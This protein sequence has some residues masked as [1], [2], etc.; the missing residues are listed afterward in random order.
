M[1]FRLSFRARFVP[2]QFPLHSLTGWGCSH[3]FPSSKRG[4]LHFPSHRGFAPGGEVGEDL[5]ESRGG[6]LGAALPDS[7]RASLAH[8]DTWGQWPG[9]GFLGCCLN[10]SWALAPTPPLPLGTPRRTTG[11]CSSVFP[12][13]KWAQQT[14]FTSQGVR[15]SLRRFATCSETPGRKAGCC[16]VLWGALVTHES[17]GGSVRPPRRPPSPQPTLAQ[18]GEDGE[19]RK[20]FFFKRTVFSCPNPSAFF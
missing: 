6:S 2:C 14:P 4:A 17:L 18:M 9:A 1:Q 12:S 16:Q 7:C 5:G 11:S 8:R 20:E 15:G 3:P 19:G 10:G 13:V